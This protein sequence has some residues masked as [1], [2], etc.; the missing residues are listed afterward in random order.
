MRKIFNYFGLFVAEKRSNDRDAQDF[1]YAP[2]NKTKTEDRLKLHRDFLKSLEAE[3]NNRLTLIENKTTQLVAQT[4]VIFA[5]L[6]LFIP[7]VIDKIDAFYLKLIIF[8]PLGL[9]FLFYLLTIHNAAKN[10]NVKK[11]KYS[12]SKATNVIKHKDNTAEDFLIEEIED[13]LYST[14]VNV[15]INDTKASNL[16]FSYNCFKVANV[17]TAVLGILLCTSLLFIKQKKDPVTIENP[18]KIE[19]YVPPVD[20]KQQ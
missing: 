3:E 6:S 14:K 12:R 19:N 18:I 10:F 5:L 15:G 11:F 4:G 20:Q 7:L 1:E 8:I 9:A 16:I 13:L 2:K 17:L